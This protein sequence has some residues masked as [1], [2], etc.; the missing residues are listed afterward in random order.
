MADRASAGELVLDRRMGES[1]C[2]ET[3]RIVNGKPDNQS[4]RSSGQHGTA[5]LFI[6]YPA[7]HDGSDT[8]AIE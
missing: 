5:Q 2:C 1:S 6:V 4:D 3:E 8:R 7:V